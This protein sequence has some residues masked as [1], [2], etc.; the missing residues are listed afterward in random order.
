MRNRAKCKLCGSIL[1]S[2]HA[3]DYVTCKCGE[4]SIDGGS[5]HYSASAKDWRNFLRVDDSGKEIEVKV[6]NKDE[7]DTIDA[8]VEFIK[9]ISNRED[10]LKELQMMAEET[11]RLP[12]EALTISVSQYDLYRLVIL[13]KALFE[14][15]E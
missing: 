8:V 11:E 15:K 10:L 12:P 1:E 13:V 3:H 6:M 2:F 7:K 14:V 4:I 9:P 5:T